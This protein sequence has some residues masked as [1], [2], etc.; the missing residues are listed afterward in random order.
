M[1]RRIFFITS[2]AISGVPLEKVNYDDI[3]NGLPKFFSIRTERIKEIGNKLS[4]DSNLVYISWQTTAEV[5]TS[6]FELQ[7]SENGRDFYC[8][9]IIPADGDPKDCGLYSTTHSKHS[10]FVNKLYYRLKVVFK[11]G[12]E[13]FTETI[14]LDLN[15]VAAPSVYDLTYARSLQ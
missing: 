12:K 1:H 6:H 14:I 15:T 13:N 3:E 4:V 7:R 9:E 11:N 10:F 2:T 8:V 5:N